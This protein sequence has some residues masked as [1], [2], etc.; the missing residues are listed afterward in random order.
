MYYR[1]NSDVPNWARDI[2]RATLAGNA[3]SEPFQDARHA[4]ADMHNRPVATCCA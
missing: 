2:L 3:A 4:L 1:I